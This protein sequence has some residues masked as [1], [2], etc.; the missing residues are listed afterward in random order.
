MRGR[1]ST[2]SAAGR[3]WTGRGFVEAAF[4]CETGTHGEAEAL[5]M[6]EIVEMI[7]RC[8]CLTGIPRDHH[9]PDC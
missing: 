9:P 2:A 1:S 8:A 7:A 3:V 4:T 5:K 6:L